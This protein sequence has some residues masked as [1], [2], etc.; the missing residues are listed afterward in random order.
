MAGN[1]LPKLALFMF[2]GFICMFVNF[3]ACV[4]SMAMYDTSQ[5]VGYFVNP[6][7]QFNYKDSIED[8]GTNVTAFNYVGSVGTSFVP[9][10][11]IV[12]VAFLNLGD[13]PFL[14][15]SLVLAIIGALQA[16]V[17]AAIVLNFTPSILGSGFEV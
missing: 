16:F 1:V 10:I 15:V 12:N 9:F 2:L 6:N 3:A 14:F 4:T 5:D 11:S 13:I 17:L 7:D 8:Q